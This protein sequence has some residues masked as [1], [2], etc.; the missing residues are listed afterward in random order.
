M[1]DDDEYEMPELRPCI[2]GL[3]GKMKSGK[4]TL[5]DFLVDALG[6]KRLSFG[7]A[8]KR[9]VA[10]GFGIEYETLLKWEKDEKEKLRPLYQAWGEGRRQLSGSN[11]WVKIVLEELSLHKNVVIDDIRYPNELIAVIKAGGHIGKLDVSK[12][13]QLARGAKEKWLKHESETALDNYLY[14]PS[15]VID[16]DEIDDDSVK[17]FVCWWLH[18]EGYLG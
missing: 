13:T 3:T 9:Q 14:N 17:H 4:T 15:F 12:K 2:I 1:F 16:A 11:Y 18:E 7:E 6:F 5:A 8:V 10:R